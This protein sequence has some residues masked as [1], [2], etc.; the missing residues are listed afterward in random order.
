MTPKRI[1]DLVL[2]VP[3][4][5]VL[6]PVLAIMSVWV[7]I[8]SPG[9]V[10]FRQTRVGRF[11]KPFRLYKLRTMRDSTES[12]SSRLTAG[13]DKRITPVGR[14]L[15]RYKLDELPQLLNVIKG[16][17]SLVGPRPEVPEYVACY[18]PGIR[19]KILSVRPGIT[20]AASIEF[21]DEEA[22]LMAADD[23]ENTY[24]NKI[25]PIKLEHYSRYVDH[26][27]LWIDIGLIIRTIG[28]IFRGRKMQR[29]T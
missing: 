5:I 7:R 15:R 10:I 11:G 14:I 28:V 13:G 25:L 8:D 29:K 26:R 18:P 12:R 20:D 23:I 16:D 2:S 1:F 24:I 9:P 4:L 17:M 3:A 19:D 6:S 22:I 27:S 21:R